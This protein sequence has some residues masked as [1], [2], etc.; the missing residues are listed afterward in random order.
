[1]LAAI[2]SSLVGRTIKGAL[3]AHASGAVATATGI[4]AGPGVDGFMRGI[5][6]S[7]EEAGFMVGSAIGTYLLGFVIAWLPANRPNQ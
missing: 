7:L 3:K 5:S 4:V 6:G 1:M 2:I